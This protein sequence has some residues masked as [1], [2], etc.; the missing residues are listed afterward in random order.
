[1][2]PHA[3]LIQTFYTAFKALDGQAMA[4]CYHADVQ[5]SDP[6]FLDLKG[7]RAGGMWKMLTGRSTDLE[8]HASKIEADDER[9]GAH[10]DASYT[11][12]ATG[13]H[14]DNHVDASFRFRDGKII[15]HH[16]SFDLWAWTRQA[17]G[18]PGMLLGWSPLVQG[19]VRKTASASLDAYMAKHG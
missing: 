17:L 14:V 8:L 6:V 15:E 18:L 5:F 19:K 11:F 4:D 1:M 3:E 2:H 12:S 7:A 10:W 9:G 13:R 16:D